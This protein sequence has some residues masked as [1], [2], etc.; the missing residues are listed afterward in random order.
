M[1]CHRKPTGILSVLACLLVSVAH[2]ATVDL[3]TSPCLAPGVPVVQLR[4]DTASYIAQSGVTYDARD[5][6]FSGSGAGVINPRNADG[7]TCLLGANIDGQIAS[8]TPWSSAMKPDGI[9][10]SNA[11]GPYR[12]HGASIRR[13]NDPLSPPKAVDTP[14]EVSFEYRSIYVA[15]GRDDL[16]EN[17]ACLPG[18]ID[19]ILVDGIHTGFSSRPGGDG[20][21]RPDLTRPTVS[22]SNFLIRFDC[23]TD[24]RSKAGRSSCPA[25]S[26]HGQ[27]FKR[28]DCKFA[29]GQ[30]VRYELS[31]GIVRFDHVP[32]QGMA[33]IS[34]PADAT[35]DDVTVIYLGPN[36]SRLPLYPAGVRVITDPVEGERIWSEARSKWLADHR[37]DQDGSNCG[38]LTSQPV[39]PPP[40]PE[41]PEITA[42]Y[43]AVS[44]LRTSTQAVQDALAVG[45][46]TRVGR[47][48]GLRHSQHLH[49]AVHAMMLAKGDQP[50]LLHMH[51]LAAR[52]MDRSS[53]LSVA[54]QASDLEAARQAADPALTEEIVLQVPRVLEVE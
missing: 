52:A 51:A 47:N 43:N 25:G 27:M 54:A 19:D 32:I 24:T 9:Q 34:I 13:V 16:L 41:P 50:A 11:R 7:N 17:D 8:T 18:V 12:V 35:V 39:Q 21:T 53:R 31:D 42:M 10:H 5:Q 20:W 36:P 3:S 49:D 4:P 2:G 46:L 6:A 44:G 1:I 22:V 26:S 38:F 28:G 14:R 37:C 45:N 30:D 29:D 40:P 23:Q 15:E 33:G 48:T